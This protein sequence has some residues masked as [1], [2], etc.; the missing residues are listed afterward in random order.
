VT[1]AIEISVT[2]AIRA[3]SLFNVIPHASSSCGI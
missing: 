2:A 1:G 3:A